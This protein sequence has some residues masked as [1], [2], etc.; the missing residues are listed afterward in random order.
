MRCI[1]FVFMCVWGSSTRVV[2]FLPHNAIQYVPEATSASGR[3]ALN[4]PATKPPATHY[5]KIN[6][7]LFVHFAEQTFSWKMVDTK[8]FVNLSQCNVL[9][10]KRA[11]KHKVQPHVR[12][13]RD[14]G[15]SRSIDAMQC[16]HCAHSYGNC[17]SVCTKRRV[18]TK[19]DKKRIGL[20]RW[21][22]KLFYPPQK[23]TGLHCIL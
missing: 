12:E 2:L 18:Y 20:T 22:S 10:S 1:F 5:V 4:A 6:F 16:L 9:L 21:H 15:F 19:D 23:R 14:G 17:V 13:V 7:I 8:P 11:R 3:N